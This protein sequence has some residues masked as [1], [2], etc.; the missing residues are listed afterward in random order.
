MACSSSAG[1]SLVLVVAIWQ[2]VQ[3][4]DRSALIPGAFAIGGASLLATGCEHQR[5]KAGRDL[6]SRV[7][8][9]RRILST[10]SAKDRFDFSGRKDLYTAYIP[11]AVAFGCADQWAAKYR[12]EIGQEPPVPSLLR[13]LLRR[14]AHRQLRQLDGRQLQ[15]HRRLRHLLLQRH[16]ELV[17]R[18]WGGGGSP[19]AAVAAA[20]AAARGDRLS[21]PCKIP[22]HTQTGDCRCSSPSSSSWCSSPSSAS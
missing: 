20:A 11:W 2:P 22:Q 16:P 3:H 19:A 18:R 5:T 14:R 1:S 10:P 7:G 6:W 17:L 4:D 21:H 8:G 9:F 12:I 13:R 15:Q